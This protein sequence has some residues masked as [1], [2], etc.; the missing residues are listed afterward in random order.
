MRK[1]LTSSSKI[2]S[3][4]LQIKRL[5]DMMRYSLN[6]NRLHQILSKIYDHVEY[7]RIG[8]AK[9]KF[10][11]LKLQSLGIPFDQPIIV[12]EFK[13]AVLIFTYV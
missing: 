5:F 3:I 11:N 7:V 10:D 4:D 12:H 13:P 1:N 8:T 2:D 6:L 9:T